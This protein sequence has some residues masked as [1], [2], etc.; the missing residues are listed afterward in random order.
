MRFEHYN[1]KRKAKLI[2]FNNSYYK[3]EN[4]KCKFHLFKTIDSGGN[5]TEASPPKHRRASTITDSNQ[6]GLNHQSTFFISQ[7]VAVSPPR[8]SMAVGT[9]ASMINNNEPQPEE[10][11]MSQSYQHRRL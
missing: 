5:N 2:T 1:N 7:S 9:R 3:L 6:M 10:R 8:A 4:N 11:N